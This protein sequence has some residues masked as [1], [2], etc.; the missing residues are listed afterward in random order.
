M[1]AFYIT[2]PGALDSDRDLSTPEAR[3]ALVQ[4]WVDQL[5]YGTL[6]LPFRVTET[7]LSLDESG[8]TGAPDDAHPLALALH[9]AR[10]DL[11]N[12]FDVNTSEGR[13]A[14]NIWLRNYGRNELSVT[15]YGPVEADDSDDDTGVTGGWRQ[16]GVN[17]VGFP[18][19]ELGIGEDVR[20]ASLAMTTV[21]CD[22]CVPRISLR[23][24]ARQSDLTLRN[25]EVEMPQ[26]KTNLIFLPHYETI[27]LL[28][29]SGDSILGGRYNIGCWQWELP[30]YPKGLELALVVVDEIWSSTT[31]T[32]DAMRGVTDK[33][34]HVMP[35][36]V[37]LPKLTRDYARAQ[38]GLPENKFVFLNVLDGNSSVC[39]K[40]PLAVVQAFQTAFP[41]SVDGVHLVL[42]TMNMGTP[43]Q[44]WDEVLRLCE[45]DSRISIIS[46]A[47]PREEVIALQS[48]ADCFVSLHRAEG[49]GRNIAEAMLLGKPVIASNFSGNTDFTND[50][51]AFM[52]SG[53][54]IPV[55]PEQYSFS[56]GQYWFDADVA[57]AAAMMQR[58]VEEK[59]E[60][61]TRAAAGQAF[62]RSHYAPESV[63]RRYLERLQTLKLVR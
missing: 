19:G 9:H 4:W 7:M 22:Q 60:R 12:A 59:S 1:C 11:R 62:V 40:N 55:L 15:I 5:A 8:W 43:S 48:L 41:R 42:K 63:G 25:Y 53:E 27:R 50:T 54:T 44:Q 20:M 47:L 2:R 39:R 30:R 17:I 16:N 46:G 18:R 29:A 26:Y 6:K 28:G 33:P 45:G 21:D 35:M 24:G 32:A 10:E 56:E 13:K 34:V 57:S 58:C 36:A 3:K 31:F 61:D 37:H 14:L 51:T 49:F 38:F 23:I 52:V